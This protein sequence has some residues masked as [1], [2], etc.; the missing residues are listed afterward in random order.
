MNSLEGLMEHFE[1]RTKELERD[2]E[3]RQA[4]PASHGSG[5]R[6]DAQIPDFQ[7]WMRGPEESVLNPTET[8]MKGR[9]GLSDVARSAAASTNPYPPTGAAWLQAQA[10]EVRSKLDP[11]RVPLPIGYRGNTLSLIH[12]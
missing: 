9:D 2:V 8:P 4:K 12:I 3:A 5:L 7:A 10:R 11:R 6:P 1:N